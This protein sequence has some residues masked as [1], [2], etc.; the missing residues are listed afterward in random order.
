MPT[1]SQHFNLNKQQSELDFIDVR[2]DR[3]TLLF[4]DPFAISQR[5]DRWSQ[6]CHRTLTTFFQRIV[7]DIRSGNNESALSRL[8]YLREPNETRLGYSSSRPQG[9]GIGPLQADQL[10]QALS[11]SA[12][13]ATG[14]ITSLEECELMIDGISRDKISDLTTNIIRGYLAEYT[15]QQCD[16]LNIPTQ[17]LPLPPYYS[18]DNDE[19]LTDY[20]RLPIADGRPLVLVPKYIARYDLAYHHL[21]Y[22]NKY[23]LTFLQAEALNARSSLVR[24]LKNKRVVVYKKDVRATFPCTKENLFHFSRQHPEVLERY[25]T[26][27]AELERQGKTEEVTQEGE[28]FLASALSSALQSIPPGQDHASEYHNLMIGIVEFIFYPHLLH[29][30]KEREINQGRKRIDI[31]MENG[32]RD[33]IFQ[34]LHA[35][36]HI[37][38]A[39]VPIECKNYRTDIAN[40]ELDQLAGRFTTNNG[41]FGMICCRSFE[42][43]STFIQRCKDT[44]DAGNG[45]II[46]LDDPT[47]LMLLG[48]IGSSHRSNI[49]TRISTLIDSVYFA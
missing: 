11:S 45:L 13:I 40:P 31:M 30:V 47:I 46:P 8:M 43:K 17:Q 22:Y 32:A 49:N 34:A 18:F 12:A 2:I 20:F 16:L 27:L 37:P 35:I 23:V 33:G 6:Q 24:T 26:E 25:R 21:N 42:N 10:L 14:F 39:Y 1:V 19:W 48:E 7:D 38:C 29:P 28:V 9:A 4:V 15:Y 44:F 36:R 41:R 3:D 5:H